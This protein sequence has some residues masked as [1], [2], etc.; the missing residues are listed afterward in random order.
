M[1][2]FL[3]QNKKKTNKINIKL[4]ITIPEFEKKNQA[5]GKEGKA[6]RRLPIIPKILNLDNSQN[7]VYVTA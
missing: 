2:I 5:M 6:Q 7:A 3:L 1:I 4:L